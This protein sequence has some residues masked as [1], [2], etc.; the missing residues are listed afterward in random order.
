MSPTVNIFGQLLLLAVLLAAGGLFAYR[1]GRLYR[2]MMAAQ[3]VTLGGDTGIRLR[4]FVSLV[5]VQTKMFDRPGIAVAHFLI[6]WGF[7]ILTSLVIV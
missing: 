3:P 4:R 1:V 2:L 6:F 5:L 7:I